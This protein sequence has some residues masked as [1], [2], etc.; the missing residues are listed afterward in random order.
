[1]AAIAWVLGLG[2]VAYFLIAQTRRA[3]VILAIVFGL[4]GLAIGIS[5]LRWEAA[6]RS[7]TLAEK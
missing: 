3:L 7:I 5:T 2:I 1:M 6:I 4:A